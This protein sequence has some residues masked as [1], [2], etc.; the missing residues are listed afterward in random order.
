MLSDKEAGHTH[1]SKQGFLGVCEL[2]LFFRTECRHVE[3]FEISSCMF[4]RF[5]GTVSVMDACKLFTR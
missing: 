2:W 1:P 5:K 3:K 4:L